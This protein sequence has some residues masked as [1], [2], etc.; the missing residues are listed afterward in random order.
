MSPS[1]I[2]CLATTDA[3]AVVFDDASVVQ[4][5][6]D[7]EVALA[8]ASAGA[9]VI[10][11]NAVSAIAAAAGQGPL[12]AAAIAHDARAGATPAIPLVAA[13]RAR[14]RAIDQASAGYVHLGLTSQDVTD[15]ALVLLLQRARPIIAA[16]HQRIERALRQLSDRHAG[17]IMLGRT[18]LQPATPI[19][20]GLKAA[21][22]VAA[23]ARSW[24]RLDREWDALSA[25]QFGGAAGTLAAF[26][27]QGPAIAAAM[28]RELRLRDA[29]PWH[30]DRDR[31]AALVAA[32]GLYVAA[33]AK[34]AR[35]IAL[36]MQAE[37]AEAAEPGGG[38]STMPQKQNPAGCVVV[39]AAATRLPGLVGSSLSSMVQEHERGAGGLQAEW[40]IVSSAVQATGAAAAALAGVVEGLSVNPARMRANLEAAGGAIFAERA[41]LLLGAALGGERARQLVAD[42]VAESRGSGEPFTATVK[43]LAQEAGASGLL[44]EIDR[45]EQYLGAAEPI[46]MRLLSE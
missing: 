36:L 7:V 15:T 37:V 3:L 4:A 41:T 38:S 6:L 14:V 42:A 35:D 21:G 11:S 8:R 23:I 5:M 30:A 19:T 45:A 16:D 29:P 43:K 31:L 33:L 24:R 1:L 22:W 25:L 34:A 32:C 20:F 17:T 10:P 40:P 39:I 28:A 9:G 26:G 46:R 18:L 2:D 44:D 12:D 13:L 27:E